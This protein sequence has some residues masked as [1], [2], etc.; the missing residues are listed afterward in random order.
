MRPQLSVGSPENFYPGM[1][2]MAENSMAFGQQVDA[3][4]DFH[5]LL[6]PKP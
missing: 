3:V 5:G 1:K 6:S 4:D 2:S